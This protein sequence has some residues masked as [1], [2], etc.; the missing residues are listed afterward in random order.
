M[1][2]SYVVFGPN[3]IG[4]IVQGQKLIPDVHLC[5]ELKLY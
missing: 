1:G 4:A 2:L 5:A 3:S